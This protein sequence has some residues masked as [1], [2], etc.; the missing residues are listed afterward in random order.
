[1]PQNVSRF[2]RRIWVALM[3]LALAAFAAVPVA[4]H[5]WPSGSSTNQPALGEQSES[6]SPD[7]S[8]G[9]ND[10]GENEGADSP[11]E[12]EAAETEKPDASEAETDA[13]EAEKADD[14]DKASEVEADDSSDS[15]ESGDDAETND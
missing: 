15:H 6:E 2:R 4:A 5:L 12:S 10:Q 11:A 9:E 3:G 14:G 8:V 13:S 1:M 7:S